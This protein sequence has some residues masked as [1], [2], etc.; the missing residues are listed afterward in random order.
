MFTTIVNAVV[1]LALVG[2]VA[3]IAAAFTG[4]IADTMRYGGSYC[5]SYFQQCNPS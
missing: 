5:T 4:V 2:A 1:F 3:A